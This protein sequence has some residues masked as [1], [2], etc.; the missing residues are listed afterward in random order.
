MKLG[1]TTIPS[2]S[3]GRRADTALAIVAGSVGLWGLAMLIAVRKTFPAAVFPVYFLGLLLIATATTR[4]VPMRWV[5]GLALLGATTVPILIVLCSLPASRWLGTENRVFRWGVVPLLEDSLRILPLLILL[6]SRRWRYRATAGASDLLLLGAA[7][8]A[9]LAFYQDA[10]LGWVPGFSA[11][12]ILE[13][14]RA[15]PHRGLLYLFPAMAVHASENLG[16]ASFIGHSGA[17]ALVGLSLGLARLLRGRLWRVRSWILPLGAWGWMVFDHAMFSAVSGT[18]GGQGLGESGLPRILDFLWRVDLRGTLSSIILY[19]LILVAVLLERGILRRAREYIAGLDLSLRH[20]ALVQRRSAHPVERLLRL[21]GVG[22]Y[23]RE[24]RGLVY[25]HYY[26]AQEYE[27]D[28]A[29]GTY[30]RD[31]EMVLRR[32]KRALEPSSRNAVSGE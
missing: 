5:A 13:A 28:R 20:L 19:V 8:G 1:S 15:S 18:G 32:H 30:L 9:G 16:S 27:Q 2:L 4:S 24:R 22:I 31:L 7:V 21:L 6:V 14:H 10:L 25:G 26:Y 12:T 17:S 23:L 29:L 3:R 11:D